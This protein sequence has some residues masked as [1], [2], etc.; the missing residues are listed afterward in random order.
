MRRA[1]QEFTHDSNKQ[2]HSDPF[3]CV[4]VA[5]DATNRPEES[6]K[7]DDIFESQNTFD[8]QPA[9]LMS[10]INKRSEALEENKEK[11]FDQDDSQLYVIKNSN[12]FSD[13]H[14]FFEDADQENVEVMGEGHQ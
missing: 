13:R 2:E 5:N 10:D 4:D 8:G 11:F 3:S 1:R 6:D 14:C 9:K 12:D 7:K